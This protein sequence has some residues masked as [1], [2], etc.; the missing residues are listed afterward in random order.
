[1]FKK[2]KEP[3]RCPVCDAKLGEREV[4]LG[5]AAHC[6]ECDVVYYYR[7]SDPIPYKSTKYKDPEKSLCGCGRCGR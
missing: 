5:Y 6:A 4:D 1:M 7:A 3:V 2:C